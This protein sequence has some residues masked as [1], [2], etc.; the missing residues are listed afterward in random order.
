VYI[1]YRRL[2][3]PR[4]FYWVHCQ[5]ETL[6]DGGGET[7][8]CA[9]TIP[10][11]ISICP[12]CV[13]GKEPAEPFAVLPNVDSI[14]GFNIGCRPEDPEE[15]IVSACSTLG[16]HCNEEVA[17]FS[18]FSVR[19]H[20]K[21]DRKPS[22]RACFTLSRPSQTGTYSSLFPKYVSAFCSSFITALR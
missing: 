22:T 15:F 20:V 21:L 12:L 5:V 6:R 9:S 4:R 2:T 18:Q 14:A 16:G 19:E 11:P 17:R 1:S 13:T 7:V 8:L 10:V 3:A